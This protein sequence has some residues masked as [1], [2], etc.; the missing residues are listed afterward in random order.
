MTSPDAV[1]RSWTHALE[2]LYEGSFDPVLGRHRSKCAFRGLG[3]VDHPLTTTL[4]RLGGR[5]AELEPAILR[6]FRKYAEP[7]VT[8]PGF[9]EWRW[10]TIGQHHGLPTRLLDWTYSPLVALHFATADL[11]RYDEDGV[12][13]AVH[14]DRCHGALPA[15]LASVL[16]RTAATVFSLELVEALLPTLEDFRRVSEAPVGLFYEPPSMDARIVNQYALFSELSDAELGVAAWLRQ[17]PEL[18]RRVIV[19]KEVKWE[20]RDKLDQANLTERVLFPGLDGLSTWLARY[21]APRR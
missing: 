7:E 20:V 18:Y 6:S 13:W 10:M 15:R 8:S 5:Y 9:S 2:L 11:E 19:P 4:M 14:L 3:E 17:R 1:A 21:Y 12:I 16:D